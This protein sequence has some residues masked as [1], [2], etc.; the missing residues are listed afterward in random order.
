MADCQGTGKKLEKSQRP[1]I[2]QP[3]RLIGREGKIARMD[4][5][6]KVLEPEISL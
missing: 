5:L 4:W 6:W 1:A 2:L 3:E